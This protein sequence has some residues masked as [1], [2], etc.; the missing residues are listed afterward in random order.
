MN[1][2]KVAYNLV[3]V[4]VQHAKRKLDRLFR[5][6]RLGRTKQLHRIFDALWNFE[7]EFHPAA[8]ANS[9][10]IGAHFGIHGTDPILVTGRILC[11]RALPG[12]Q[13]SASRE[14]EKDS[15]AAYCDHVFPQNDC[16]LRHPLNLRFTNVK[17][18]HG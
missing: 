14:G 6:S 16:R 3:C 9:R 1:N 4:R 15:T 7:N 8:R 12:V 2:L 18:F 11:V 17:E 13:V 5:S 10:F